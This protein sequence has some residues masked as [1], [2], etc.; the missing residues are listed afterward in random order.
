MS[1]SSS[2]K[3]SISSTDKQAA[4]PVFSSARFVTPASSSQSVSASH[5]PWPSARH[6]TFAQT[7]SNLVEVVDL[8]GDDTEPMPQKDPH[9]RRLVDRV[10]NESQ[11]SQQ[12][13]GAMT[14][15]Q[16]ASN[17]LARNPSRDLGGDLSSSKRNEFPMKS[18]ALLQSNR[19]FITE[20]DNR[21]PSALL[22]SGKKSRRTIPW[23]VNEEALVTRAQARGLSP[24]MTNPQR[25]GSVKDKSQ[26]EQISRLPKPDKAQSY[27]AAERNRNQQNVWEG[28]KARPSSQTP[29]RPRLKL[30]PPRPPLSQPQDPMPATYTSDTTR[31][32][33]IPYM[34]KLGIS[35]NSRAIAPE[36]GSQRGNLERATQ[37]HSSE[38]DSDDATARM[39]RSINQASA[40]YNQEPQLSADAP[41]N[42]DHQDG[43]QELEN[44]DVSTDLPSK[45]ASA[46][47]SPGLG[48]RLSASPEID[49]I[50]MVAES[51]TK[52]EDAADLAVQLE[53]VSG[54]KNVPQ[55]PRRQRSSPIVPISATER[56]S[57]PPALEEYQQ[58]T[59]AHE[60]LLHESGSSNER[61]EITPDM[62]LL[63]A[64]FMPLV[65]EMRAGQEYLIA[66]NLC[67]ARMDAIE[68][69]GP[70]LDKGLPDPFEA[71]IASASTKSSTFGPLRRVQMESRVL[72]ARNKAPSLVESKAIPFKSD[73]QSLPK[74]NSIV[75]LGS[76]ILAPNDKDLRYLPYFPSEE[77][78]DGADVN[79]H[80]RREELLEG[81]D[82]RIKFLPQ[83]RKCA[84]QA[85]FWREHAE[86]FLEEVG[87][88]SVDVMFYLLHDED[89][90]WKP[91]CQLSREA[92]SQWQDR[93]SCCS[94]CET[95][96]EGGHWDR[97]SDTLSK[98]KPDEKT[99]AIAGLVCSVFLKTAKFSIWHIVS[100]DA[101]VQLLLHETETKWTIEEE[102]KGPKSHSLCMLCHLFDCPTHGAY[103]E[104][105]SHSISSDG[106]SLQQEDDQDPSSDSSD[107]T[108]PEAGRN[109][110]QTVA[111]PSRPRSD[112]QKHKCGFF[113]VD[114]QTRAVDILGLHENG[115][116][117]GS[118]SM[119]Q[120]RDS[121]DPGFT[122]EETCSE[123][124]FWGISKR[125]QRTISDLLQAGQ[126]HRFVGW[127]EKEVKIYQSMLAMCVQFRRGPCIMAIPLTRPCSMIFEEML[128]DI[129][130]VP[131][132]LLEVETNKALPLSTAVAN[133]KDKHYWSEYS[134]TYDHHKR[135]PF[136]PCSHTGPCH[137]NADCTCWA[138]KI[139]C[140]WICGCDGAC[141]RR[142]Q[143]CRCIAR[144]AK[145]CFKD[146]NCDCW[147]LNRECDPWLCGK[148]GVLEVLD[149]VNRH[150]ASILKS[151]CK[152]AMIQR[153]IPK[154]TLKGPSEVHGWGLFAG[155]D[156]RANEYIGE[157]K[158]E[159]IS[160][161]ESNRRGLVYHYRGIEYLFQ[162]NKEQEIDSSRAG[163]KMRFIN[164][165]ERP[166][167]INVYP[168]P[169]LCNGVQRIGLFA[170]RNIVAGEEMF[171]RYGYP[172]SVTKHFWEKEDI[173]ARRRLNG[174]DEP[175]DHA[176]IKTE[177]RQGKGVKA[178]VVG[179]KAKNKSEKGISR[180]TNKAVRK[181]DGN[182]KERTAHFLDE[183]ADNELIT[184]PVHQPTSQPPKRPPKRK[185]NS[186]PIIDDLPE[187]EQP[188]DEPDT[189]DLEAPHGPS[190]SSFNTAVEVID[191]D[192]DDEEYEEDE[193]D[194]E[195]EEEDEDSLSEEEDEVDPEAVTAD[196]ETT[197]LGAAI[198]PLS[199]P[200]T[201]RALLHDRSNSNSNS[202]SN[203]SKRTQQTAAARAVSLLNRKKAKAVKSSATAPLTTPTTTAAA[204]A[205]LGD[206]VD[207]NDD[208]DNTEEASTPRRHGSNNTRQKGRGR[209]ERGGV[210]VLAYGGKKRGRP[211]GWKKGV[212]FGRV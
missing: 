36:H 103:L 84:E 167:T 146:S 47:G 177:R 127:S 82:N 139:A 131:H 81:F 49:D 43:P 148:C 172:E 13:A 188:E 73:A 97:L 165:S 208:N 135:R 62:K 79:D 111:L 179:A 169:M 198:G 125:S 114:S 161:E 196:L 23:S 149:P 41:S 57:T 83:E 92:F 9:E 166:S 18:G 108:G 182:T 136:V 105:D 116:V 180:R 153:N 109:I 129:H 80:K 197:L 77:E 14:L 163:N 31:R 192:S 121:G 209:S 141:S 112:G 70:K 37:A 44:E 171:F 183:I 60:S 59:I 160:E 203:S 157:Y 132:S 137:K 1:S 90:E 122:D 143:G 16:D 187:D 155:T 170:K 68:F 113:C 39:L 186:S 101:G 140:E 3:S 202:N 94:A 26:D 115:E 200:S 110:R 2:R 33:Q 212:D 48:E 35:I 17:A 173:E 8:T 164:N 194:G 126:I 181:S 19:P 56:S 52:V 210:G 11:S 162:L 64:I 93:E 69:S 54:S 75:R 71:A 15:S 38:S 89:A 12:K 130:I 178:A 50:K 58:P 91:E 27:P 40:M 185:R 61:E 95:K 184:S 46:S 175:D 193:E 98:H 123:S 118:C 207:D 156:I 22:G 42:E 24:A 4:D 99:L 124:C 51:F 67:R 66:G 100:T 174:N 150:D 7:P 142:F 45:L 32:V 128:L 154:R 6:E 211:V 53:Q 30:N 190:S 191:S 107:D 144:G 96:F 201:A 195:E 106:S 55:S 145:V 63:E 168:Q 204:N 206:D 158:G 152:N 176:G 85:E 104:D 5:R 20:A 76:N 205:G 87:C 25:M 117:K 159:V 119:N 74:Y 29:S 78:K 72:N 86:Y 120:S 10:R 88:T 102:S 151:R 34:G 21:T 199:R 134:Q 28:N 189:S 65:E 133:Y 147:V 138:N